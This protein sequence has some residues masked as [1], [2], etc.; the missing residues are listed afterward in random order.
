MTSAKTESTQQNPRPQNRAAMPERQVE[1]DGEP[2]EQLSIQSVINAT[3]AAVKPVTPSERTLVFFV[4]LHDPCTYPW[5]V[6]PINC[7]AQQTLSAS[8]RKFYDHL[9]N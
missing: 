5:C 7:K 9:R 4:D 2:S 8:A 6:P 1:V 3:A